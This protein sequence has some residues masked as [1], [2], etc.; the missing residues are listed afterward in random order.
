MHP[1]PGAPTR[2]GPAGG[3]AIRGPAA[4]TEALLLLQNLTILWKPG[5]SRG[6][7]PLPTE[8]LDQLPLIPE[9]DRDITNAR[10][11]DDDVHRLTEIDRVANGSRHPILT[12]RNGLG[13]ANIHPLGAD[14]D[15]D[16]LAGLKL[17]VIR[18][19]KPPP[20][21]SGDVPAPVGPPLY[22]PIEKVGLA[23]ELGDESGAG[24]LV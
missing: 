14:R 6:V 3:G 17:M 9:R 18:N 13:A 7:P 23:D 20:A 22:C 5:H 1:A 8:R 12:R 24:I 2:D 16:W 15:P 11:C 4:A 10:H 19:P 21:R